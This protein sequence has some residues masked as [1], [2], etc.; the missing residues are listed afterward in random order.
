MT[1]PDMEQLLA[2]N[3]ALTAERDKEQF[4]SMVLAAAMEAA[5]CDGG[6]LYLLENGV[7][8][9]ARMTTL[10]CGIRQGG[11]DGFVAR[12]PF[13]EEPVRRN[14]IQQEHVIIE[15]DE[16]VRKS[17]NPMK[18]KLN[19]IAVEGREI[20][21]RDDV[22]VPDNLQSGIA[23][24]QPFRQMATGDK[25]DLV[26]PR[27][28]FLDTAEQEPECAPVPVLGVASVNLPMLQGRIAI[29]LFPP[30]R[31]VPV[32][33]RNDNIYCFTQQ[34]HIRSLLLLLTTKSFSIT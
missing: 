26:D 14:F 33:P 8:R 13:P 27:G 31:I 1:Q 11:H 19:H 3:V 6:T 15:I 10:S 21:C 17:L 7:L 24:I 20:R 23:C 4:L 22:L 18:I 28:I 32:D 29:A 9:F 34:W 12:K 2:I 25:E 5:C 16:P 30:D